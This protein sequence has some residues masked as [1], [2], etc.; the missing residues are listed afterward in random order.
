MRCLYLVDEYPPFFRGGLGTYAAEIVPRLAARGLEPTV[1]AHNRGG[2]PVRESSGGIE[3]HRPPLFDAGALFDLL[4]GSGPS[5]VPPADR[6]AF[7]R[8][9]LYD[10]LAASTAITGL[11]RGERGGVDLVVAHDWL[12]ALAGVMVATNLEIPFVFH[13]HSTEQGRHGGAGSSV[14]RAIERMAAA[15]ADLVVTVSHAMRDELAG[16]GYDRQKV[17]VVH[18]GVDP[19]KY[20]PARVAPDEATALRDRLGIGDR[21]LIL[22]IGRLSTVKG[23][24]PLLLAMPAIAR[25]VPDARLVLVGVGELET[26]AR[27]LIA[28]L[29]LEEHLVPVFRVLPEPER[30][31]HYAASDLCVFPS[32]Y[33]PFGIVST[34]AMAMGKPV[35]VGAT[36]TSGFR[37]QVIPE[38]AGRCGAWIDPHDPA[39]I[40]GA[41]IDLLRDREELARLGRNGR[42]RVLSRFTW[43]HAADETVAVYRDAV[44]RPARRVPAPIPL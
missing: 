22:F 7:A 5:P 36:G 13:V 35:V 8:T 39:S 40:A 9:L 33:E 20:D 44:A 21:P 11:A 23:V 28:E 2:D 25:A 37:E 15:R 38:G 32:L 34:E 12:A 24:L 17:R 18:N 3:V 10:V 19:A 29:G 42:D 14:R 1:I 26:E 16:L 30:I 6:E 27:A 31:L 4:A 41:V 43:E